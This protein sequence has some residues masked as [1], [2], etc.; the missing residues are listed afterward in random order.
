MIGAFKDLNGD[1][2]NVHEVVIQG[3]EWHLTGRLNPKFAAPGAIWPTKPVD[4]GPTPPVPT[5]MQTSASPRPSPTPPAN[6]P[7]VNPPPANGN[8][9]ANGNGSANGNGTGTQCSKI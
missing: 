4:A 9:P 3:V 6:P 1:P 8:A 7:A 2:N 5:T